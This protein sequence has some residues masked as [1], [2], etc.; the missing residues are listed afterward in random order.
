MDKPLIEHMLNACQEVAHR[1]LSKWEQDF[2]ESISSQYEERGRLS[3]KQCEVLERI[4]AEKT[5]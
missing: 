2:I 5:S 1:K 4:Y 3:E